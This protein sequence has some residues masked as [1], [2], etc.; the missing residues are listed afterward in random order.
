MLETKIDQMVSLIRT[1]KKITLYDLSKQLSWDEESVE[2]IALILEKSGYL[3]AHYPIDMIQKP[4]VGLNASAVV[5]KT[6]PSLGGKVLDS[7][8]ISEQSTN[9]KGD[10]KIMNIPSEKRAIYN[11]ILPDVSV[12][13]RAYLEHIKSEISKLMLSLPSPKD[14]SE[15]EAILEKR[16]VLVSELINKDLSL[17]S[18]ALRQLTDILISEMYGLGKIEAL[19]GDSKLEEIVI[20][21]HISPVLVYHRQY[22][23]LKTTIQ[24]QTD[25]EIRNYSEQIARKVGKQISTLNPILDAHISTSD[26]A[27]ATLY[28][29]ST[30]GNTITLRLF[31]R[32]PWTIIRFLK[33]DAHSLSYEMAALL[34][35]ALHYEMNVLVAGGTAS[36]K[37]SLLNALLALIPPFQRIITIED[38]RELV[39]PSYQWNWVPMVTRAPNPEGLGEVT[40]LDLVVNSLRM[41]PDRIVMGE[42]R[43]KREAEV[44]FEA[45]HTGHSVYATVHANDTRETITRLTNPPIDIPLTMIPAISMI[46][47]QY[48]N[49]RTGIRKTF[50]ISEILPNSEANVLIQLDIRSGRFYNINKSKALMNTLQIFTGFTHNEIKKSLNEKEDVLKWLVKQKLDTVDNVGKAMA[51]YYTNTEGFMKIVKANKPLKE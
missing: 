22:G 3:K 50:Q 13:V 17:D 49:R 10:V 4:W 29:I 14:K 7:Y 36:G 9:M 25:N 20:N 8:T 6:V 24:M 32:N 5:S 18:G 31:A 28:P 48:R 16:K 47:V 40:M 11:I 12:Y 30:C 1:K 37:T 34:W 15:S 43:R 51:E 35:Q 23:W 27:N 39:L 46:I 44:L 33:D 19:I 21:G 45:I 2:K 41:R 26:R 38:T 42:I